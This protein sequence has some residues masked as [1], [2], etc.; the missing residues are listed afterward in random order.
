[1]EN[2]LKVYTMKQEENK[3][4]MCIYKLEQLLEIKESESVMKSGMVLEVN[5]LKIKKTNYSHKSIDASIIKHK[6]KLGS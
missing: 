2:G 5:K 3:L 1:M 4:N 6:Y